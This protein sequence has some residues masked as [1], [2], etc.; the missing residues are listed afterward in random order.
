MGSG[1]AGLEGDWAD[2]ADWRMTSVAPYDPESVAARLDEHRR[3]LALH[4]LQTSEGVA[5]PGQHLRAVDDGWGHGGAGVLTAL[6][7][8]EDFERGRDV[9]HDVPSFLRG[10][11]R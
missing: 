11:H 1:W 10:G 2:W 6:A 3:R 5:Y 8:I 7:A 9:Q 4:R